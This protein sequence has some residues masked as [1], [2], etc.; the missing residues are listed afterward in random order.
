MISAITESHY[1]KFLEL[2]AEFVHWLAPMDE[3]RL[4]WVLARADYA[5]QIND[6]VGVLIAYPHNIDY[7]EHKNINWIRDHLD[8]FYYIDRIII[9]A[10]AQGQGF[11]G[12]LYDDVESHARSQGFK[13]IACEVN[14]Q[15]NNPASHKF[16]LNRDYEPM[17]D[18][19]YPA[20]N[21]ALRYYKKAL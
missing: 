20:F 19:D 9:A 10:D 14:T 15:P 1:A 5:R 7:P 3:A 2:N 13:W 18:V 12:K 17:G 16:H 21:A 6:G 11:G 4:K 8:R